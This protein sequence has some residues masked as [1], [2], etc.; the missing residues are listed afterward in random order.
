MPP[1]QNIEVLHTIL[2]IA[3]PVLLAVL[4][5]SFTRNIRGLDASIKAL[6]AKM[7]EIT[8]KVAGHDTRLAEGSGEFRSIREEMRRIAQDISGLLDRERQRGCGITCR[9]LDEKKEV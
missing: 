1:T 7:E 5:W 4:G 2:E 6:S 9:Y 8:A 3:T